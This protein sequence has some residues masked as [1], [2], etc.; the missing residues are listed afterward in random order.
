MRRSL[1][2]VLAM[3]SR[4]RRTGERPCVEA[5]IISARIDSDEKGVDKRSVLA[6]NTIINERDRSDFDVG[7]DSEQ[8]GISGVFC[9]IDAYS[10][11]DAGFDNREY[12]H[13]SW[14]LRA[15]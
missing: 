4:S 5:N 14:K 13:F 7:D 8:L 1:S 6:Y 15:G 10:L 12:E 3:S 9:S 2:L 11:F